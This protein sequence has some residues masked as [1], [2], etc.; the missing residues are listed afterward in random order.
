MRAALFPCTYTNIFCDTFNCRNMVRWYVGREDGPL[1]T[2]HRLC[3]ACAKNVV[4]TAPPE[5]VDG[6]EQLKAQITA[7]VQAAYESHTKVLK[8]E[9]EERNAKLR[10]TIEEMTQRLQQQDQVA[11]TVE[12]K[13]PEVEHTEG[14]IFRCLECDREFKTKLALSSHMR[15]HK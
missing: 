11:R 8:A 1:S 13:P 9:Y 10:Q 12:D 6:S 7:E 15:T 4:A 3:E 14:A 2:V 5:L